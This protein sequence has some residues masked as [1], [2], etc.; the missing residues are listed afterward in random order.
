M[1]ER[2]EILGRGYAGPANPTAI[3]W[4]RA[5]ENIYSA[6]KEAIRGV[7]VS[8]ISLIIASVPYTGWGRYRSRYQHFLQERINVSNIVVLENR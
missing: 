7:N 5:L 1:N 6:V 3:G 8:E 2:G 4:A